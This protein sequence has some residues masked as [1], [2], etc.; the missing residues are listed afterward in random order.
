[1]FTEIT[2]RQ[3]LFSFMKDHGD[4]HTVL[5]IPT[6][7]WRTSF[8]LQFAEEVPRVQIQTLQT[9]SGKNWSCA[10]MPFSLAG[11]PIQQPMDQERYTS[12]LALAQ[13]PEAEVN[14]MPNFFVNNSTNVA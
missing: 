11:S 8:G 3:V 1:M 9:V 2:A 10:N 12:S 13:E 4:H 14:N 6:R 7:D 5:T